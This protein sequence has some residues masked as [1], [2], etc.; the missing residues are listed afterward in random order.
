MIGHWHA[1]V[2]TAFRAAGCF[3]FSGELLLLIRRQRGKPFGLDW[4]IPTGKIE[5]GETPAACML[6][7]LDEEVGIRVAADR[8]RP[9]ARY[10]VDDRGTVFEYL[11]FALELAPP[12]PLVLNRD[13]VRAAAWVPADRV[14]KRR[15]VPYFY[16]T[17]NDALAWRAHGRLQPRPDPEPEARGMRRS[18]GPPSRRPG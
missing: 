7:E 5:P 11:S 10:L 14:R 12:P 18:A 13:E 1:E 17:L 9:L 3:C 4:G 2:P 8:L 15:V 16:N 6:R